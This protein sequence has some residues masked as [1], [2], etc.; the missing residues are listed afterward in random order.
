MFF[1]FT[2]RSF[3]MLSKEKIERIN[4]LA[5]KAKSEGL[6]PAEAHEQKKL[7]SEY[8]ENF[9]TS[10]KNQLHSVKV[11]D[12]K[13]DDVTPQKLKDSKDKKNNLKY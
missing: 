8:L 6:T 9:R 5:R 13:G 4:T 12:S 10:F 11:V 3:M 2:E 1:S 7:R